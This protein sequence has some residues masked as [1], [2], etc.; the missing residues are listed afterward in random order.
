M[1]AAVEKI[2]FGKQQI[3]VLIPGGF[4]YAAAAAVPVGVAQAARAVAAVAERKTHYAGLLTSAAFVGYMVGSFLGGIFTDSHGRRIPLSVGF[5]GLTMCSACAGFIGRSSLLLLAV[6]FLGCGIFMG[7]GLSGA[8]ANAKEWSPARWRS[9]LFCMFF[10]FLTCGQLATGTFFLL[11]SP[12][13]TPERLQWE[14]LFKLQS[15]VFGTLFI[16]TVCFF[17]QSPHWL[18]S[19]DRLTEARTELIHAANRNGATLESKELEDA[20]RNRRKTVRKGAERLDVDCESDEST[21]L[22]SP[23]SASIFEGR[24]LQ[25]TLIMCVLNFMANA[26]YYGLICTLPGTLSMAFK[27]TGTAAAYVMVASMLF[28]L[29]GIALQYLLGQRVSRQVNLAVVF[30]I[31]AIC[32]ACLAG[33][34]R[35][36]FPEKATLMILSSAGCKLTV[37]ACFCATY[38]TMAEAYPTACQGTGCGFCMTFGRLG[39]VAAPLVYEGL[40]DGAFYAGLAV[41]SLVSGLLGYLL[42]L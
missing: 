2:G 16:F 27:G 38:L 34:V 28:E 21:P 39:A 23:R 10:V 36:T 4:A 17:P 14:R 37:V 30:G 1:D 29:P 31:A 9:N 5:A 6:A 42:K 40:G 13:L 20:V 26:T 35:L 22:Q 33:S 24:L 12:D 7:L 41:L 3:L 18:R 25:T 32:L 15:L 8:N 19:K 11:T